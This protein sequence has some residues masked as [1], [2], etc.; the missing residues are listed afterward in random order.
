MRRVLAGEY[1]LLFFRIL[2]RVYH[3]KEIKMARFTSRWMGGLLMFLLAPSAVMAKPPAK[4]HDK[5]AAEEHRVILREG[6]PSALRNQLRALKGKVV[7]VNFWATWC[8]PCVAEFPD[9]V[10]LAQRYAPYGL[11]LVTVSLDSTGSRQQVIDFLAKHHVT[12]LAFIASSDDAL[13]FLKPLDPKMDGAIPRTYLFDRE[14]KIRARFEG[15]VNAK[16]LEAR[17][18][19]LLDIKKVKTARP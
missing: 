17:V 15:R 4:H 18:R 19:E 2:S 5:Q 11:R 9:L 13:Q 8:G 3:F 10:A 1:V 14:G 6:T 7:L 16:Q 12:S